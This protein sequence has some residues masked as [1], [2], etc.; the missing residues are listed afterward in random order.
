MSYSGPT[1]L[2][3]RNPYPFLQPEGDLQFTRKKRRKSRP[4]PSN[5]EVNSD[6]L[7]DF[8]LMLN[9]DQWTRLFNMKTMASAR[10]EAFHH[11]R[12]AP[13]DYLDFELKSVYDHHNQFMR[14]FTPSTH[15]SRFSTIYLG[16][17]EVMKQ[18][19]MRKLK[20]RPTD[21]CGNVKYG[22]NCCAT[23]DGLANTSL[24][25]AKAR[26]HSRAA[27]PNAIPSHH[28]AVSNRGYARKYN[29]GTF[30]V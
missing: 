4:I 30:S 22:R 18:N 10:R 23:S 3:S 20:N 5:K 15:G 25:V 7:K 29:G 6:L 9:Q 1:G 19:D 16:R 24:F 21:K 11:D 14:G 26:F 27:T 17:S 28:N 12:T 2:S 13:N 8:T